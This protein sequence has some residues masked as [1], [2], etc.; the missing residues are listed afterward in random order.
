MNIQFRNLEVI[1]WLFAV[2]W[3]A[4]VFHLEFDG[5]VRCF[6]AFYHFN[7]EFE[8]CSGG[9]GPQNSYTLLLSQIRRWRYWFLA[10]T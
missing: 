1:A 7:P 8:R 6:S 3:E 5:M 4:L 2:L 10:Y 9:Q